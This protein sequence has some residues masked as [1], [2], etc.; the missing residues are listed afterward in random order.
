M[1]HKKSRPHRHRWGR[2]MPGMINARRARLAHAHSYA[3]VNR[4]RFKGC[5]LSPV[6]AQATRDAPSKN[7]SYVIRFTEGE[8]GCFGPPV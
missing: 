2:R 5:S 3:G 1:R 8:T 7:G 6:A 4:I